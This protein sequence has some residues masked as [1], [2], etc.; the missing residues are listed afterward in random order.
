M[1]SAWASVN[2]PVCPFNLFTKL[3]WVVV[4]YANQLVIDGEN[5]M[6]LTINSGNNSPVMARKRVRTRFS[7]LKRCFFVLN[8]AI[9]LINLNV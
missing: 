4:Y 3:A 7:C 2:L 8:L 5:G 6:S 9:R 1:T